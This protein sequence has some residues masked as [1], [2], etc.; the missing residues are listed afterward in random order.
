MIERV[1][2]NVVKVRARFLAADLLRNFAFTY[3]FNLPNPVLVRFDAFVVSQ[4]R[5]GNN[6]FAILLLAVFAALCR[7]RAVLQL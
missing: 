1:A 6:A 3:F 7:C 4:R 2:H 5:L